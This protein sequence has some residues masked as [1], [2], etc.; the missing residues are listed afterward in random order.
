MKD[1][2]L[3][4]LVPFEKINVTPNDVFEIVDVYGQAILLKDNLPA[5]I[6]TRAET[7]KNSTDTGTASLKISPYTL[8]DAMCLVLREVVDNQMHASDL[9]DAI[10]DQKLYFQKN[11]DKASYNQIR[12][13]VGHYPDMFEALSGN[14]IRLR[15]DNVK[16][17]IRRIDPMGMR[18]VDINNI[19]AG[20]IAHEGKTFRKKQ[21][22]EFTFTVKGEAIVPSTTNWNIPKSSFEKALDYVPLK[23]VAIIQKICQGPS[24]VYAILMDQRI[25]NDLW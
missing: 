16:S 2:L 19:W 8:H 20:I 7:V 25:R 3:E 9:A 13:R 15:I 22:Q 4:T 24:Y 10:Y 6:I 5:Y 14:I 21:G 1:V 18:T 17:D 23:N 11:G 12:A